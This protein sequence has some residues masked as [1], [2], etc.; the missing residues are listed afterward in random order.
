[1]AKFDFIVGNP[2][3]IKIQNMNELRE[4]LIGKFQTSSSGLFNLYY[5]FFELGYHFLTDNGKLLF[6][7]PSEYLT[8]LNG[9]I[10]RE[11][12]TDRQCV[13]K[14]VDL[15]AVMVFDAQVYT[16]ITLLGKT[17]QDLID[18]CKPSA[19]TAKIFSTPYS[20][21]SYKNLN[22]KDWKL[23]TNTAN[24]NIRKIE[25]FGRPLLSLF[26]IHA[27]TAT[28]SNEIFVFLP[29]SEDD[30][31][32]YF[33]SNNQTWK[34][35]K[36]I[37]RLAVNYQKQRRVQDNFY[38]IIL[39]YIDGKPIPE[40]DLS[41]LYPECYSYLLFVKPILTSREKNKVIYTPF[42]LYSRSQ[43]L[44]NIGVKIL[45]PKYSKTPRFSIDYVE[46]SLLINGYGLYFKENQSGITS[47]ENI[48]LLCKILNS[49]VM[50][51][52][53]KETSTQ[54]RGG[55]F[56]YTKYKIGNF[57]IPDLSQTQIHYLSSLSNSDFEKTLWTDVYGL[58]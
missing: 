20:Q 16:A 2:P 31:F 56:E 52:Y 18:Y 33:T 25:S 23:L 17:S 8:S 54:I 27:H 29:E 14:I 46:D 13:S 57:N 41:L 45:T 28:G 44:S 53:M 12:F 24:S 38:R 50:D 10:L 15:T 30:N 37:T 6:I 22:S 43:S 1:M 3:Y 9:K 7:T 26:D 47:I 49:K 51:F 36:K 11:F 4:D 58:N 35:E 32:Y 39:P 48:E 21:N 5:L 40:N 42:Y 34:I 19:S 55:Y